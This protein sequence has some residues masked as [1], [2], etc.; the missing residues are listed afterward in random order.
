M[1]TKTKHSPMHGYLYAKDNNDG[2]YHRPDKS[3][4]IFATFSAPKV[5]K[6]GTQ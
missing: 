2:H 1:S 4:T 3:N 6:K 5:K